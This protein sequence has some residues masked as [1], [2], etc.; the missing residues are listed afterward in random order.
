[1]SLEPQPSTPAQASME[2]H[3]DTTEEILLPPPHIT[4]LTGDRDDVI[5]ERQEQPPSTSKTPDIRHR[6]QRNDRA[7]DSSA[8]EREI[9]PTPPN[10]QPPFP[11]CQVTTGEQLMGTTTELPTLLANIGEVNKIVSH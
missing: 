5:M 1:M 7:I 9:L 11:E 8:I 2:T 4:Q 3:P 10:F 6:L